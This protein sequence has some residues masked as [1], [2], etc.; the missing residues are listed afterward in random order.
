MK[1][2]LQCWVGN[3]M[4]YITYLCMFVFFFFPPFLSVSFDLFPDHCLVP[5]KVGPCRGSFPRWYYNALTEKCEKF[6]FGGCNPN[7]NNYLSKEECRQACDQ[8]SGSVHVS[9]YFC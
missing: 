1:K 9:N 5:K 7:R 3:V 4:M 6:T 2:N 8:V